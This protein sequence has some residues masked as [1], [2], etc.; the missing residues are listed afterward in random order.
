MKKAV[1]MSIDEAWQQGLDRGVGL[2]QEA[3]YAVSME[4]VQIQAKPELAGIHA[5]LAEENV[6]PLAAQLIG[7]NAAVGLGVRVAE[8]EP[9]PSP[10]GVNAAISILKCLLNKALIEKL[11]GDD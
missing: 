7:I 9:M 6:S 10:E 1:S 3:G 2:L 5:H 11:P 4:H 8:E